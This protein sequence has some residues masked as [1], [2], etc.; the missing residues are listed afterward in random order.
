MP[1]LLDSTPLPSDLSD[2]NALNLRSIDTEDSAYLFS[3]LLQDIALQIKNFREKRCLS[4]GAIIW[5]ILAIAIALIIFLAVAYPSQQPEDYSQTPANP[6]TELYRSSVD[7]IFGIRGDVDVDRGLDLLDKNIMTENEI[8][9]AAVDIRVDFLKIDPNNFS[10]IAQRLRLA[11]SA[12]P[13]SA[14]FVRGLIAS[15]GFSEVACAPR[16]EK[17]VSQDTDALTNLGRADLAT[18]VLNYS[19]AHQTALRPPALGPDPLRSADERAAS[20][21]AD[22]LG[23]VSRGKELGTEGDSFKPKFKP[24]KPPL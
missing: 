16:C 18:V 23:R 13:V 10:E 7:Y 22:Y 4:E 9:R 19:K 6:V 5:G 2:L 21:E 14:S 24:F 12:H 20:R 11:Q 3:K 8:N 1:V 15:Q 17:V